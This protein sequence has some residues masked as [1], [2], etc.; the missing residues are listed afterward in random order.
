M[1]SFDFVNPSC[2]SLSV[3]HEQNHRPGS[4]F[5][6]YKSGGMDTNELQTVDPHLATSGNED[7]HSQSQ[8][9]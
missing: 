2:L 5:Q 3:H 6:D 1:E 7:K 9:I 4:Y 8:V